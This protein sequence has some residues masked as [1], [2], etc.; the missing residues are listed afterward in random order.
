MRSGRIA[1]VIS[2]WTGHT[3]RPLAALCKSI[4]QHEPGADYDLVLC[5]NGLDF[6]LPAELTDTF[7]EVF[8]RENTGFNLGAWDHAWRNLPRHDW[9]LFMQDDC[10]VVRNRWL[11]NFLSRFE[12]VPHCGLVGEHLNRDWDHSWDDLTDPLAGFSYCAAANVYR[13]TLSR[14]SVLEGDTG[15]HV[16]TVV[17]FTSRDILEQVDGYPIGRDHPE[18]IAAEIA[19]SRKIAALGCELVQLGRHRHSRIAHPQW[20][21]T[22]PIAK[23]KQSISKRLSNS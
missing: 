12:S 17:Q 10:L 21:S 22:H 3:S 23:I 16:T 18:A 14:W 5:A 9:F 11:R 20:P 13:Q 8:I 1:V 7:A 2:G 19:F 15:L 6:Q 4:A